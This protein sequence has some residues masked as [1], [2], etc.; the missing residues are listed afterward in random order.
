MLALCSCVLIAGYIYLAVLLGCRVNGNS[1]RAEK[2][3]NSFVRM[4]LECIPKSFCRLKQWDTQVFYKFGLMG[5]CPLMSFSVMP[6]NNCCVHFFWSFQLSL[7][8]ICITGW[9]TEVFFQVTSFWTNSS[10]NSLR[11]NGGPNQVSLNL[12]KVNWFPWQEDFK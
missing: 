6:S 5:G 4:K 2:V 7:L 1:K 8:I 12:T 3:G 11:E 9:A 10:L